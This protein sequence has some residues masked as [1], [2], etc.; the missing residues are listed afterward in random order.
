MRYDI[1]G[2]NKALAQGGLFVRIR[3]LYDTLIDR[4]KSTRAATINKQDSMDSMWR[5]R[6]AREAQSSLP[7]VSSS[8]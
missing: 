1:V 2:N 8:S 7:T 4:K 6:D 3:Q 5:H